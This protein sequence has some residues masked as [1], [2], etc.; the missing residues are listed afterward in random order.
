M[1]NANK[2]KYNFKIKNYIQLK[3]KIKDFFL[4]SFVL[5]DITLPNIYF[6]RIKISQ[7]EGT[8]FNFLNF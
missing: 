8:Q 1:K 5:P 7:V 4:Y 3:L 6:V 2:Q